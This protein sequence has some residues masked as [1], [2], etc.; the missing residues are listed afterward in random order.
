MINAHVGYFIRGYKMVIWFSNSI[1][2]F[3]TLNYLAKDLV[4]LEEAAVY[5]HDCSR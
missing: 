4:N 3:F 1:I 5:N 2:H